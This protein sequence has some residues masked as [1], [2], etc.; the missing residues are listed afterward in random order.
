MQE[1]LVE[2]TSF[3]LLI[4]V[5][6]LG[7]GLLFFF[8]YV[9]GNVAYH[10]GNLFRK[11]RRNPT[12]DDPTK[13]APGSVQ[14]HNVSRTKSSG[15]QSSGLITGNTP[16]ARADSAKAPAAP[17]SSGPA[18]ETWRDLNRGFLSEEF[19]ERANPYSDDD[20]PYFSS[21]IRYSVGYGKNGE[22]QEIRLTYEEPHQEGGLSSGIDWDRTVTYPFAEEHLSPAGIAVAKSKTQ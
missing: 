8:A 17:D 2:I 5:P 12:G 18:V 21:S 11:I 16:A 9:S 15:T 4:L 10:I 7:V 14:K 3:L 13:E 20:R 19:L 1:H 6:A 22:P